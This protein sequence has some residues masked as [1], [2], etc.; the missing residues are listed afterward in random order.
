MEGT[1]LKWKSASVARSGRAIVQEDGCRHRDGD[2]RRNI[3]SKRISGNNER[4]SYG[5]QEGE[6]TRSTFDSLCLAKLQDL[7]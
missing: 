7:N 4:R 2:S 5:A 1:I 6:S 3:P